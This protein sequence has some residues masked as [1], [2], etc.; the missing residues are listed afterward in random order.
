MEGVSGSVAYAAEP[1]IISGCARSLER[2]ATTRESAFNS[3]CLECRSVPTS[4]NQAM[5]RAMAQLDQV[6]RTRATVLLLGE[7][8][9]GKELFAEA[10]HHLSPRRQRPMV[11]VNCGAIPDELVE[12]ELFGHER[13]A[14]TDA[15]TRE[16]GRFEAADGSTLFL[17]EIGELPAHTQVKLLRVLEER[18]FER[19]GSAQPVAVDVRIVAASNR[20]LAQAVADKTFRADLFYR[21][22]VFP[23]V[24]PPLRE[25]PEDIPA[26]VST[27][28]E[29]FSRSLCKD[30]DGIS[31]E[32]MRR[33]QAHSWPGNVREL[34]NVI[35]R[36]VI[37]ATGRELNVS[38]PPPRAFA[39]Q[40]SL[41]LSDR[42]SDHIR[43]V[44]TSTNWRVRGRGGA[45][46]QLAVKPSTLES[47][48]QRLGIRRP[49]DNIQLA[50]VRRIG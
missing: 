26:M 12:N 47:R 33:L 13:G 14:Y 22:N 40:G 41:K 16:P 49:M 31:N 30:I 7:T 11:R 1:R 10:L 20:N 23:I 3:A 48:M 37:V 5:Q 45:A 4:S 25:R 8:G 35:E 27:F 28:I 21:L 29:E 17:D 46:E 43:S 18:R 19:L 50:A 6:A 39:G 36:A 44:L 24:I 15:V 38:V 32:S 2:A 34:R 9:V 42:V